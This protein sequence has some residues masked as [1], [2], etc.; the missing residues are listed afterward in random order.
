MSSVID[1]GVCDCCLIHRACG[2]AG[3]PLVALSISYCHICIQA[4]NYPYWLIVA[5]TA[6]VGG[7]DH[8]NEE[9]QNMVRDSLQYQAVSFDTF[10]QDVNEAMQSFEE[11][12][13]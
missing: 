1:A 2:V 12:H 5:N 4:G 13:I 10:E 9:W 7:F 8:A 6:A 11:A 3:V